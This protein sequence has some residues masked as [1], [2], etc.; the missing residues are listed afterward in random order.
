[1]NSVFCEH[2]QHDPATQPIC[3]HVGG[4]FV[5]F[6]PQLEEFPLDVVAELAGYTLATTIRNGVNRFAL[7]R[8]D[9]RILKPMEKDRRVQARIQGAMKCYNVANLLASYVLD[10][11]VTDN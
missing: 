3:S 6:P 1:M 11:D 7:R 8:P 2:L 9:G 5:P 4:Q 10:E